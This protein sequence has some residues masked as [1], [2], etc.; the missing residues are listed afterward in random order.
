M[1]A[2][3]AE[4]AEYL[5]ALGEA[6]DGPHD[7][8][9]AAL[10]LA[11]LDHADRKLAPYQAHLAEIGSTARAEAIYARDAEEAG[12]VLAS[13]LAGHYGYDGDR[14]NF[15]DPQNADLMSVIDRRRGI[16][17]SLGILYIH[18]A[19]AGGLNACGLSAPGH[20]LLMV[21]LRGGEA[22]IDPFHGGAALDR[23]RLSAA[24]TLAAPGVPE[25]TRAFEPV[26]DTDVLLRLQNA[27]KTR[28]IQANK[29]ERALEI[30]SR[31]V[32]IAPKRAELWVELGRMQEAVGAL[33]AARAAYE[34]CLSLAKSGEP[35]H[36]EAALAL[37]ALKRRLN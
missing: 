2:K 10:M 18:A 9:E 22:L 5:Q 28:A 24:P 27:F 11:A 31:M 26:S 7:I 33:G 37:H 35:L 8:A 15:E 23:E 4:P 30:A 25:D 13:I 12:R 6:G 34:N 14:L 1:K 3:G 16:P 20:F 32:L 29:P 21:G 36:N 17:V 19:R